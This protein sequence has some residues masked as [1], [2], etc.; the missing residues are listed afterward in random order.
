MHLM[1]WWRKICVIVARHTSHAK[2]KLLSQLKLAA[3]P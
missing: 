1:A 2:R 3:T